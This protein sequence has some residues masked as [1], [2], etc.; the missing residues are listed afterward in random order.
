MASGGGSGKRPPGGGP[1]GG[2]GVALSGAP[3]WPSGATLSA[4][5][6]VAAVAAAADATRNL[7]LFI[8]SPW[9]CSGIRTPTGTCDQLGDRAEDAAVEEVFLPL[10]GCR[11]SAARSC[12]GSAGSSLVA[13]RRCCQPGVL[14]QRLHL[15]E[16]NRQPSPH[17]SGRSAEQMTHER[18]EV[19]GAE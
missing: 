10:H 12:S 19:A 18:Q 17:S 6:A 11:R 7:R 5:P 8:V 16:A 1:R 14:L 13:D 15:D 9:K 4:W 3:V 2:G